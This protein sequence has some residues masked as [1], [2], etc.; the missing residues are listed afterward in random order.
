MTANLTM[1]RN[2][3]SARKPVKRPCIWSIAASDSSGGAGMQ[4]DLAM[5]HAYQ[6]DCVTLVTAVTAQSSH[7]VGAVHAV[8]LAMM[9]AQWNA[10]LL[11]GEPDVIKIGWLPNDS[12]L[13]YW[14]VD[15]L[16][17]ISV[18]VVWDPVLRAS[19][20]GLAHSEKPSDA[21][22]QLLR[23]VTVL[24]PNWQEACWLM[25]A[26]H[27]V[28]PSAI[29]MGLLSKGPASILITGGAGFSD[30]AVENTGQVEDL[31]FGKPDNTSDEPE[32]SALTAFRMLHQRIPY[33]AHGT[34]CHC[35][36]ALAAGIARGLRWYDALVKAVGVTSASLSNASWRESGYHNTFATAALP[37]ERVAVAPVGSH[38]LP[39]VNFRALQRPLGLY[40]IVDNL[41]WLK[42]LLSLGVDTL[43]WR[44]KTPDEEYREQTDIAV[45]LC[46]EAGVPLFI[47]DD[48]QLA[49]ELNAHGVHLGQEDLTAANLSKIAEANLALGIS[50][51]TE[52]EIARARF[53]NP[54][55]I[56]FGPVYKPL[57]KAL[58]YPPLGLKKLKRWCSQN[59]D[60]PTTCIGGITHENVDDVI[61]AG[62]SSVAIVTDLRDD[63]HLMTRMGR[64][65]R[66]LPRQR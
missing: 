10:A 17:S 20:G 64:L 59:Q 34:G 66:R 28:L 11:D 49:I 8:P 9:V 38:L 23:R 5:A 1:T 60:I 40:G 13:L 6:V 30:D 4:A 42:R 35:S 65:R 12:E 54:S 29:A 19:Q 18:P 14:L 46:R 63:K 31:Y 16:D 32:Q 37:S 27:D 61:D 41:E 22:M 44:V 50:T 51:H 62:M 33:S 25:Q 45:E 47:N 7:G 53:W 2:S 52:W 43:Q 58:K 3:A 15:Q 55:Y 48:W 36:A 26:D 56:A 39:P 21:I 57:S 24:T